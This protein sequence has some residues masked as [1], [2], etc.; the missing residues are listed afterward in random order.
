MK[1]LIF[2]LM[3]TTMLACSKD[4][5]RGK[6]DIITQTRNV[7]PFTGVET[8]YD[9]KAIVTYGPTQQ[10]E[11]SGYENLI[12]IME[13]VVENGVLKLRFNRDYNT[14]RNV[15]LVARIQVPAISSATIHGSNNI[16]VHNF[17]TGNQFTGQIHGSGK[18]MVTH[19]SYQT[20]DLRVNGSGDIDARSLQ[21]KEAEAK[22]NGSG[23]VYVAVTDKLKATIQGS[24]SINYWGNPSVDASVQ[25]SGKVVKR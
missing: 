11:V 6:G 23:S 9:I 20:A 15:N 21:A 13:T 4:A 10:V 12:N 24:G 16:E 3:A 19:S 1:A 14:V 18:I 25:G 2:I 8:H 22:I 17:A 5:I 7:S